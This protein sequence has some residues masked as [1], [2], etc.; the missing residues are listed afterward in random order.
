MIFETS[1]LKE[2]V[3]Q[4][5]SLKTDL[6][7][8]GENLKK[9]EKEEG[10]EST[11]QKN[12]KMGIKFSRAIIQP[13]TRL[14]KDINEAKSAQDNPEVQEILDRLNDIFRLN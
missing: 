8:V 14:R 11:P 10:E 6:D 4:L 1:M 13:T 2:V 12:E 7:I 3:G 5:E 9:R